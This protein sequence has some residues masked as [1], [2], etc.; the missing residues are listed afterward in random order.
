MTQDV[1]AIVQE[2]LAA[3][4]ATG[5][6]DQLEQVKARYLGKTGALTL[7]LKELGK[8]PAAER[9]VFGGRVNAAKVRLEEALAQR[10][11]T[12][13]GRAMEARLAEDRLDVT[14]PGR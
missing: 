8:L 7:L 9:P 3:F 6:A 1:D 2:A 14:L 4:A 5:D 13:Q 10:R 11:D 12:I